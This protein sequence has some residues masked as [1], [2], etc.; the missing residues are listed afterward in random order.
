M[1]KARKRL[2]ALC[3][4]P[5]RN[6]HHRLRRSNAEKRSQP[7][8]AKSITPSRPPRNKYRI[9][10]TIC[11]SG[12]FRGR[13]TCDGCGKNGSGTDQ[14][15]DTF[16]INSHFYIAI[17][18][19]FKNDVYRGFLNSSDFLSDKT[20][21]ILKACHAIARQNVLEHQRKSEYALFHV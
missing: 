11:R 10:S 15:P 9:I 18:G 8:H 14:K 12:H 19:Q 20:D 5:L 17:P 21:L 3:F 1:Q 16:S 7:A 6:A 13:P 2:R 4:N